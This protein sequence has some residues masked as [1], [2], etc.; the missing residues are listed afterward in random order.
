CSPLAYRAPVLLVFVH[1]PVFVGC[2]A[3]D[4]FDP[5]LPSRSVGRTLP[6]SM[7][8]GTP[9]SRMWCFTFGSYTFCYAVDTPTR[10]RPRHFGLRGILNA[11]N[12]MTAKYTRISTAAVA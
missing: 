1:G 2:D 8:R 4:G 11:Q 7:M 5:L 12:E 9:R 6:L 10:L 3:V